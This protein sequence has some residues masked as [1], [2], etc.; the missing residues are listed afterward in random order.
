MVIPGLLF[1]LLIRI[2]PV[3]GSVIAWQKY[4]IFK[5]IFKSDFVGWKNFIE[6]FNYYDFYN[7]FSNTLLIGI[8]RVVFGLPIPIFLAILINE[9]RSKY[10]RKTCQSLL[11]FPHLLSW[12]VVGQM[13]YS[14][15]HPSSGL[16]NIMLQK[17]FGVDP[18]FFLGK[19]E[20]FHLIVTVSYIWKTAGYQS[21]VYLA[22]ITT[23]DA[24][25][26]EAAQIDG[27]NRLTMI[28][29]ITIPS[30]MPVI[31]IM[32][33]HSIGNFLEIGFDQIYNL[34]NP[35]VQAKGDI[36]DT[37]IYRVGLSGGRYSQTTAIGLFK[38]VIGFVLLLGG[39][40]IAE[41]YA[42]KGF[43]K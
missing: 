4:S 21:I 25:M 2:I 27:A 30:I 20:Y 5:G 37:Y 28:F 23:I 29:K 32:T 24:E 34:I 31:V 6:M 33:L 18:V 43:F 39:N 38:S 10:F 36:F 12:V 8:Y 35:L 16:I 3:M 7:V 40:A 42:G 13:V 22:A 41:R 1:F 19:E 17:W 9:V 15:L 26:Y 11:Y 14:L